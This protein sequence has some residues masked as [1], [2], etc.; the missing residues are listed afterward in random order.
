MK[1]KKTLFL[2]HRDLRLQD[3]LG[4]IEAVEHSETVFPVFIFD[5]KQVGKENTYFSENAFQFM[6]ESLEELEK[7]LD[8]KLSFFQGNTLELIPQ[9]IKKYQIEALF[10]NRD[11]TPFARKR[12][13]NIK[14][15]CAELGIDFSIFDDAL[16]NPPEKVVKKDGKP[17]EVFTPYYKSASLHLV[18]Y[19]K[20]HVGGKYEK[21]SRDRLPEYK[22]NPHIFVNGGRERAKKI[23]VGI[24]NLRNYANERDFPYINQTS[25]LSAHHKFGTISIRETYHVIKKKLGPSHPLIRQL[26]WR[27]FFTHI[28]FFYPHVFGNAF[29]HRYSSINWRSSE[30]DFALWCEGKTGFPFVDAGMRQLNKTGWMHNRLRM[31]VASF[32]T[33]DLLIDWRLGERYFA[34]KLVDYDPC[35]NNGSWQWASSTGCD[36]Q[37]YFRIFNPWLQQKR[38]D[39]EGK[40]IKE[41]VP[42]LKGY[43]PKSLLNPDGIEGYHPLICDHKERT[44]EAKALFSK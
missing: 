41:Y 25:K 30:K 31:V 13:N 23:L 19:P 37:P 9:I 14:K 20:R 28:A 42:E 34:Q 2:F 8:G 12:D 5:K 1:Y 44:A 3:N 35:V 43:D 39:P 7:E 29:Q 17:Y 16:L 24:E 11:Y 33:K 15:I 21:I 6:L 26:Y 4:F 27:D 22:K 10:C 32:L 36:A 18:S 40:Y 38:F